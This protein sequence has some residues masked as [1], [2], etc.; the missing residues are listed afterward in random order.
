MISEGAAT[1]E[2]GGGEVGTAIRL[3][4]G[5]VA[6]VLEQEIGPAG[7]VLEVAV[8]QQH[9]GVTVVVVVEEA[10]APGDP[11]AGGR[12]NGLCDGRGTPK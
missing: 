1:A 4:E 5:A 12:R 2:P 11:V 8:D 6:G 7:G 10:A 3:D 9:V